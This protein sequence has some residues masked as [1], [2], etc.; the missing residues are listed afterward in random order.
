MNINKIKEKFS[1]INEIHFE[2]ENGKNILKIEVNLTNMDSVHE[3]SKRIS[4]FIDTIDDGKEKYNL[5]VYSPGKE[6][7]LTPDKLGDHIGEYVEITTEENQK[8]E[9]KI[10]E[11]NGEA[12]IKD[13]IKGRMKKYSREEIKE[14]KL[15]FKV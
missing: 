9:A 13:N 3:I 14:I 7:L 12:I 15:I 8:L 11:E 2:S 10:Y 4:D 6:E 1:E 5:E